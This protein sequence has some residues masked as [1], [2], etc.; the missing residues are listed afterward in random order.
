MKANSSKGTVVFIYE[1]A[2]LLNFTLFNLHCISGRLATI[3]L[4]LI[5]HF[6]AAIVLTL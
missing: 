6:G 5:F 3:A 2:R 4:Y 1:F